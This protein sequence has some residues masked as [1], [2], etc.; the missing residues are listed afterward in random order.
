MSRG[1]LGRPGL[2][3]FS[4][5]SAGGPV[6][7]VLFSPI[8]VGEKHCHLCGSD[9]AATLNKPVCPK[10]YRKYKKVLTFPTDR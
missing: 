1:G 5:A 9:H 6:L 3:P 2:R 10:C 4:W 8:G 7:W